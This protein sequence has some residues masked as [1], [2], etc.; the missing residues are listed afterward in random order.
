M[1]AFLYEGVLLFGVLMISGW[2][3]STL[4]QM[5]DARVGTLGLQLFLLLTLA[6][7]FCWFWV[8]GGQTVAMRAWHV[9]V[10][11]RHG[12]P[13]SQW[14]A[15]ARFAA[16]WLWFAPALLTLLLSGL[17]SGAAITLTLM[18]GV[19]AY[20]ALT[21]LHPDRQFLHDALCG[22]RLITWRPSKTAG[23]EKTQS[24]QTP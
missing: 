13:L 2:L 18:V 11:D 23:V 14:R 10:V 20:A 3:Y 12:A 17:H 9:R 1:A 8:H 7:Y 4:T 5:R 15:L 24:P 16:A 21:R 19:G 6:V 22:T